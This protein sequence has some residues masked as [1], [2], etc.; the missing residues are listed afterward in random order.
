MVNMQSVVCA[1]EQ[2][3]ENELIFVEE[4]CCAVSK[5]DCCKYLARMCEV[6]SLCEVAKGIYY[7]PKV[8]RYGVIPLSQGKI[9]DAFTRQDNGVVIGYSLFNNLGLTTQIGKTIEVLTSQVSRQIKIINNVLLQFCD[10]VYSP[11]VKSTLYFLE[12]LRNFNEIQDLNHKRFIS[13]CEQYSQEYSNIVFERIM[14]KRP[15]PE[16]TVSFL[17]SILNYYG[18]RNSLNNYIR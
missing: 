9:V 15:Y 6:G 17:Q 5:E 14:Q 1:V 10:L 12:V 8:S 18:V 4:L 3:P 7:R 13:L 16:K 11:E 2:F